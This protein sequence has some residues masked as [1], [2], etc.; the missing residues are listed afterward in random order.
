[1]KRIYEIESV[2]L[3]REDPRAVVRRRIRDIEGI[4]IERELAVPKL[5][6][7]NDCVIRDCTCPY[8]HTPKGWCLK[9]NHWQ[10]S[11][12]VVRK[13][14]KKFVVNILAKLLRT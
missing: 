1:M 9:C 13:L 2:G 4:G 10:D 12:G 3:E 14:L 7:R 11:G 8:S 5:R 6:R